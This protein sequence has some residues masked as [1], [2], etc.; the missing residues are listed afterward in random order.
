MRKAMACRALSESRWEVRTGRA[1]GRSTF[2]AVGD[3]S[4]GR[5][6]ISHHLSGRRSRQYGW[7][8][9]KPFVPGTEGSFCSIGNIVSIREKT[10]RGIALR[11]RGILPLMRPAAGVGSRFYGILLLYKVLYG[12]GGLGSRCPEGE[13]PRPGTA[14][15]SGPA[16]GK[17]HLQEE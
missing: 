6:P 3:E 13:A 15:P 14:G 11:R 12:K 4:K 7:Q 9:G 17:Y 5:W 1:A 8:R 16:A 2:G 10:L